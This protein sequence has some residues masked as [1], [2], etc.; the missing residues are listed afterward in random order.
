MTIKL[1]EQDKA[2]IWCAYESAK[3]VDNGES[4]QRGEH[5]I[6]IG[7]LCKLGFAAGSIC[8]AYFICERI[9]GW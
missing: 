6:L 3:N 9:F 4:M 5:A 1:S 7:L 8:S 2:D